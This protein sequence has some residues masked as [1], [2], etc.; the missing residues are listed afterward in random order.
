VALPPAPPRKLSHTRTVV[1]KGYDR[2][3]GLWDIEAEMTDVKPFTFGVPNETTFP[4]HQPIHHLQIRLTVDNHLVIQDVATSLDQIPHAEC[5]QGPLHM[6][7]L[8][9][10]TLGRGWRKTIDEHMGR[11]D[12]CTTWPQRPSNPCRPAGRTAA[13]WQASHPLRSAPRPRFWG[14]APPGRLTARR[15]RAPIRCFSNHAKAPPN[16]PATATRDNPALCGQRL[17]LSGSSS[18]SGSTP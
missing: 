14:N 6:H 10:A 2:E 4:A 8:K 5:V 11:T 15:W 16:Q 1:Y 3:D 18:A 13:S 17:A 12:G 7:K 9:G